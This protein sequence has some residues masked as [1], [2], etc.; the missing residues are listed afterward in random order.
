MGRILIITVVI[1]ANTA[2]AAVQERPRAEPDQSVAGMGELKIE[3]HSPPT[4]LESSEGELTFDVQGVASTIGGVRFID[5]MLVLDTSASLRQTDPDDFRRLS[6]IGLIESLSEKSDIQIGVIGFSNSNDL[7]QPLTENRDSVVRALEGLK[8]SGGTDLAAG[9]ITAVEE[10]QTNGRQDSSRVIVLF[11]DGMSNER[12]A[13]EAAAYARSKGIAVQT[14]LLGEN[15]KGGFLLEEIAAT[16][17]GSFVWVLDP[18]DLPEAFLNLK[19]TGV[20][21]VTLSVNDS[22]PRPALL[23]AGAFSGTVPLA[24]GENRIVAL[25]T[26]LDGQT[27]ESVII[28]NVADASCASLEVSA[29]NDGRPALSLNERAVEIVVDA[30]RSMWG[31]IDGRSKM[32]I[33]KDILHDASASLPEDLHLALRAYGNSSASEDNDCADSSL[34]VPFSIT[35]SATGAASSRATIHAAVSELRPKG[36]T[37]IAYALRQAAADFSALD[38]ERS[39]VLVTDG[40]ESCGGDP[41]AA[42]RDLHAQGITI[43]VI[44]FGLNNAKAEDT[45]SLRTIAYASGGHFFTANSADELRGALEAT[46]GT[47][48]RVLNGNEVVARGV[49]GG[50]APMFLP[51]GDYAIEFDSHPVYRVP[52]SLAARDKLHLMLEREAGNIAHS[53]YRDLLEATSCEDAIAA[54]KRSQRHQAS[55]NGSQTLPMASVMFSKAN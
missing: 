45:A 34:L 33:A 7:L 48:Y 16:T 32:D 51:T 12:K 46:V 22:E 36:Q 25:A 39:L 28:V 23:T 49:L 20:D 40:I 41:V 2:L 30:S 27:E 26:S 8:R 21:S 5:M 55:E 35:S 38:S 10:L 52:F 54:T 24:V 42:A 3:I 14:L 18:T 9:I 37:P 50:N 43:H 17:G 19:T 11:T 1:L 6:A 4:D 31:Q 15:L 29:L 53:E 47:G 44:G 13:R